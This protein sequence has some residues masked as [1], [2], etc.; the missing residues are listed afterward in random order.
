MMINNLGKGL[1]LVTLAVSGL[2]LAW[3]IAVFLQSTDWG[4]K[5]PR[6]DLGERIPSEIDK[7]MAALNEA[8]KF[9]A[10][11]K[12]SA[13]SAEDTLALAQKDFPRNVLLYQSKL[14]ELRSGEG[15]IN[16]MELKYDN[17]VLVRDPK[18]PQ[19]GDPKSARATAGPVFDPVVPGAEKSALGYYADFKK[20]QAAIAATS[21]EIQKLTEKEKEMTVNLIGQKDED[22]KLVKAGMYELLEKEKK[23]QEQVKEEMEYLQPLWVQGLMDAQKLL[24]RMGGLDQ[25]LIEL[26]RPAPGR[27]Q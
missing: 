7:R 15:K 27:P 26:K 4:W 3:T 10:R 21:V 9:G 20:V 11:A 18:S 17:G 2:F 1:V 6:K 22:G 19:V 14:K 5:D 8:I 12:A 23:T 16:V 25:R 13:K 24:A